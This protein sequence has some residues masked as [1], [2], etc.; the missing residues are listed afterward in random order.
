MILKV[1]YE[2]IRY[3]EVS[4]NVSESYEVDYF[5]KKETVEIPIEVE[6][7][8][9]VEPK[10]RVY[11]LTKTIY[12]SEQNR[13]AL[14]LAN[15]GL[16]DA[17]NV[18]VSLEGIEVIQPER[19]VIP[20]LQP[21]SISVV[22]FYVKSEKEGEVNVTAKINYT[23]FDGEKWSDGFDEVTFKI[24][25]E[26]IGKGV[27]FG[28]GKEKLKRGE[29]GV[30]E[31]F[32]MNNYLYPIKGLEFTISEPE[33]VEFYAKRFLIGYLNSGEVRVVK[34]P[35][36]VEE[37]ADFGSKDVRISA[38]YEILA[39]KIEERA[40][41]K[42]VSLLIEEEPD[43]EVLNKPVV[44]HGENIVTL[45]IINVG[46]DAKNIHFKLNPS[47]GIKLKMPE[48]FA[49]E[50]KKGERI[51]VS[52][53]VDVDDDVISGNEYRIDLTYKAEDLEG[54][55][56]TGTFYAYLLVKQRKMTDRITLL[57]VVALITVAVV[58]VLKKRSR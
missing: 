25:V 54:K 52:F 49:S 58:A 9:T 30:L 42:S 40:I 7:F 5:Y 33:G 31:L 24:F 44:Y 36:R 35:Y 48:A 56:F 39:S 12:A 13:I 21:S 8:Q 34:V 10:F 28:V 26:K 17:R 15:V 53:R 1:T 3:V 29:S 32:V 51:N 57:A 11:P 55:E 16:S 4:G 50:L 14:Q 22:E 20:R 47:P 41:E 2:R 23:Y 19:V 43:F 45:E 6:I 37:D 38:K 46:G 18:E 27:E